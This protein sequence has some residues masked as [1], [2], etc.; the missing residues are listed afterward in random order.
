MAKRHTL[1][2]TIV[3]F[4]LACGATAVR[5]DEKVQTTDGE[6]M[7]LILQEIRLL[8]QRMTVLEG[9]VRALAHERHRNRQPQVKSPLRNV[10]R[11]PVQPTKSPA[12]VIELQKESSGDLLKD[13]HRLERELR[14]RPFPAELH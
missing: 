2:F 3:F 9:R 11:Q 6:T 1:C 12:Q 10:F 14:A 13:V 7:E 5:A 8:G 4:T